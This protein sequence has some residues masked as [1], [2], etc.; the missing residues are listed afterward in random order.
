[1]LSTL[2]YCA[3]AVIPVFAVIALGKLLSVKGGLGADFFRKLNR[4]VYLWLIPAVLFKGIYEADLYTSFDGRLILFTAAAIT[5]TFII[6]L[7]AAKILIKDKKRAAS[8]CQG[9]F[10]GNYMFLAVPILGNL[11]EPSAM[12]KV[13]MIAPVI[14]VVNNVLSVLVFYLFGCSEGGRKG[15]WR[16]FDIFWGLLTNPFILSVIIALPFPLIGIRLPV[17]I[18]KTI[19]YIA[20]ISTTVALIGIGGVFMMDKLKRDLRLILFSSLTKTVFSAV[21]IIAAAVLLGFRGVEL[22]II[23]LAFAAPAATNS[24]TTAVELGGDGDVAAGNVLLST[25]VSLFTIVIFVSILM[26]IGLI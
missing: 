10:K 14:V 1:M 11:L 22:A 4:L 23:T 2:I 5:S 20:S 7:L 18:E 19:G 16:I 26:H 13:M 21:M 17:I 12:G 24:Y 15:L 9:C 6:A 3:N 8:F 25:A